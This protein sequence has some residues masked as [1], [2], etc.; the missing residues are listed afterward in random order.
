MKTWLLLLPIALLFGVRPATEHQ[1]A[2]TVTNERGEILIGASIIIKGTAQGTISDLNGTFTLASVDSCTTLVISYTGFETAEVAACSGTPLV[3]KL[4]PGAMLDEV[5]VTG[6]GTRKERQAAET[7]IK[8]PATSPKSEAR[9]SHN[10]QEMAPPPPPAVAYDQLSYTR[11]QPTG[12]LLGTPAEPTTSEG[13]AT[14]QENGFIPTSQENTSTFSIDV[15]AASYS[16]TRRF[17]NEGQLP[18][19]DAV[20]S[21]EM[22]NYFQYNYPPPTGEHPVQVVTEMA[23]CPWQEGHQLLL[24]GMRAASMAK[25]D[26]PAANFV[27][28]LDVSGS[29]L[30]AD[31]LPLLVESLQLLTDNLREQDRVAIVVYAGAAGQVLEST[32]GADKNKIKEALSRLRA[33]GSTAGAAG[34]QQ[35]YDVARANFVAGGNN[36][37]ILATDGDFNVGLASNEELEALIVK[38]RASGVFL[39][40][41]GFGRGNLQDEKME[42]LADKGN[43][44]YAYIDQLNEAKKVL[45]NEFGGTLFTVA[46]DVKIQVDFNPD[47]VA[48]YRLVGY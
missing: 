42:T 25:A 37:V 8:R 7:P 36:R 40:I 3:V 28:L 15:D 12:Q 29:M 33:G 9:R 11:A 23:T 21:E 6:L 39:S 38:E 2:G 18:P 27:F 30:G 24:V 14:I 22:I 5:V 32:S 47:L 46:K 26:L 43:G 34:I 4:R 20:R 48:S 45:V 31:R 44:N 16:N 13:Y 1:L 17:L 19:K 10:N 41:L 35:A